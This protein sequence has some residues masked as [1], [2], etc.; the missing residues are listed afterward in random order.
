MVLGSCQ[1][2][3]QKKDYLSQNANFNRKDVYE[4]VLGR[5]SLELTQFSADASTYPM[6]FSIENIRHAKDGSPAPELSEKVK[7]QEWTRN[8]TGME[9]SIEEIEKKR[10]WVEKPFLEIREGSGDF[11][12]WNAPSTLIHA[13]PDSGYF[14][15]VKV[16]NKGNARVFNDFYLRP[17]KEIP[18]EPY[19]YDKYT[20]KRMREVRTT[21]DGKSYFADY[22]IHPSLLQDLYYA[23]DSMFTDTLVSVYFSK[24]PKGNGNTLTFKFLD[25]NFDP[26]DPAKFYPLS[27]N[28]LKPIAWDSLVH[29]FNIQKT[30]AEVTYQV[31]YPIPLSKLKTRYASEGEAHVAFGYSRKGFGGVRLDAAFG[32]DFSIYEPGEW[33]IIFYFRRNP[34]FTDD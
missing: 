33:T 29:G 10:I 1:K 27:N 25:E 32:L 23:K 2:L 6:L 16:E 14:F 7:V 30:S 31:A 11:I 17:V 28:D 34:L 26:I 20:H 8:Y 19:E 3:P 12:F 21:P 9:K 24:D 5:T 13:Y 22:T 18:Y 15:D 4:P